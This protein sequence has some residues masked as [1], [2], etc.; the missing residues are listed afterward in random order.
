MP[1]D[2]KEGDDN[3]NVVPFP[4]SR[5]D[6][7]RPSYKDLGP[8]KQAQALGLPKEQLFG[9]WCSRCEGIWWGYMLEVEC[10]QCGNRGG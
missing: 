7:P 3:G 4:H 1:E 5:V 6:P 2:E 8:G 10:P 9:H